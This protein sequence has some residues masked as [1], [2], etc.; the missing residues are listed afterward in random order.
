MAAFDEPYQYFYINNDYKLDDDTGRIDG[1]PDADL[2]PGSGLIVEGNED[3]DLDDVHVK[4]DDDMGGSI[5]GYGNISA[6]GL[7][8]DIDIKKNKWYFFSFPYRIRLADIVCGGSWVFRIYDGEERANNGYGGWQ[9]MPIEAE[10]LEPGQGYIFRCNANTTLEIPVEKTQ[11]GKFDGNDCHHNLATYAAEGRPEDASWN[12]L[13]NPYPSYFDIEETGYDGPITVWNGTGYESVRPGDDNY[14]LR[15]FEAFFVQ[16]PSN[17]ETMDYDA[18]GRHT[19]QQWDGIVAKKNLAARRA[20]GA[21]R[22]RNLINLVLTAGTD[23]DKTRVVFNE[24]SAVD[25]EIG[26]DAAKFIATDKPQ[27]YTIDA[28]Q[29]RYAINERPEG[30]VRLGYVATQAGEMT[31]SAKRMDKA[32]VL[33]DKETGITT[34][35]S[36]AN[37]TFKTEAGTFNQRLMLMS[38]ATTGIN[39]QLKDSKDDAPAYTLD[40]KRVEDTNSRQIYIQNGKKIIGK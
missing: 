11:F 26:T 25:Y 22:T 38:G 20:Q 19:Y 18:D 15:P 32:V 21:E 33:Y 16:K 35:L 39:N 31:I 29:V 13:G 10:Y 36:I 28:K 3:Q 6:N 23:T 24:K 7:Y 40:G 1:E 37:Y 27:L 8:F 17:K 34:D 30:E 14:H 9:H 4:E 2:N 12:F 5:I